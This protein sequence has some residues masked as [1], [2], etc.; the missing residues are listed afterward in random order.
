VA[1][2]ADA[3]HARTAVIIRSLEALMRAMDYFAE[4]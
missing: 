2:R 1:D 3:D 4:I